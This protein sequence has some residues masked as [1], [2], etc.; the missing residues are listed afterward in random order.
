MTLP[1]L[2]LKEINFRVAPG[3]EIAIVG[4]T[5]AGKSTLVSLLPRFYD[6]QSGRVKIDGVDIR[7]FQL[8]SL[9][10]KIAMILQPPLRVS[11]HHP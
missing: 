6:P 11:F 3:K 8:K 4:P 7:D 2:I 1:D 10:R 9:R 5:G